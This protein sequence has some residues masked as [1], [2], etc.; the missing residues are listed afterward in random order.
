MTRERDGGAVDSNGSG[1]KKSSGI[2]RGYEMLKFASGRS[3]SFR[4]KDGT[5][6]Q[7]ALAIKRGIEHSITVRPVDMHKKTLKLL[8]V[9]TYFCRNLGFQMA[10]QIL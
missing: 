3:G 4:I 1:S 8:I 6:Y 5:R 10:D 7:D 2:S 9:W